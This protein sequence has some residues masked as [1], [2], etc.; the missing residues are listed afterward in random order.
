MSINRPIRDPRFVDT[1]PLAILRAEEDERQRRSE[2]RVRD[3]D[4]RRERE[5]RERQE[6]YETKMIEARAAEDELVMRERFRT[7]GGITE[8][9]YTKLLPELREYAKQKRAE[10]GEAQLGR[11]RAAVRSMF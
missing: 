6:A 2:Q 4:A 1:P 7:L 11:Q 5:R 9:E 10:R 3:L 8:A